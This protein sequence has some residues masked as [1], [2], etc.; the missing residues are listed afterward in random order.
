MS[1]AGGKP[2]PE[3]TGVPAGVEL[4]A[5]GSLRITRDNAVVEGL[6]V[7]GCLTIAADDVTIRNVRV[8]CAHPSSEPAVRVMPDH[9]G[10]VVKDSEIDGM[11][12]ATVGVGYSGFSLIR[13]DIHGVNDGAR[14]GGNTLIEGSW[15]HD[16]ARKGDLHPDTVQSTSGTNIRVRNNTL[17]AA[18]GDDL[19]NAAIMLGTEDG[20]HLLNNATFEDNY[21]NGGN[22]T[23]NIRS[24]ANLSNV[25][26]A[27]NVYGPD[28]RYGEVRAPDS[29]S[30]ETDSVEATGEVVDVDES[31]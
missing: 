28:H 29:I 21:L 14:I 20:A 3:N 15:I 9:A 4:K 1:P 22:Y 19:G 18:T 12:S 6:D 31:R 27:N 7:A 8:R 26:F 10:L 11:G 16:L 13:V 17:D 24:D 23:V 5:S 2:G 25:V 30:F